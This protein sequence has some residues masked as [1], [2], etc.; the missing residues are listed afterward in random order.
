MWRQQALDDLARQPICGY[1]PSATPHSEPTALTALALQSHGLT[2]EAAKA[3]HWLAKCQ[4]KDGSLGVSST[5]Q[6]PSWPTSLAV[7]VWKA[8]GSAWSDRADRAIQW[9][10]SVQGDTIENTGNLVGHDTQIPGWPWVQGTHSWVEP[11]ALN[12][13]ALKASQHN[14]HRRCIV[15]VRMLIDRLLPA[16]GCNYGNT[17]VLGQALKPHVMPTGLTLL[18]LAK[19]PDGDMRIRAA[20]DYLLDAIS[21]HTTT[22]SLS[23]ALLGLAAQGVTLPHTQAVLASAVQRTNKNH[24]SPVQLALALLAAQEEDSLFVRMVRNET[25]I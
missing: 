6:Q 9:I 10:I 24:A 13:V 15:G 11:T 3:A 22:A 12:V 20:V 17:V 2:Q 7:L 8:L 25:I 5:E 19:E 14:D 16:G 23:Y 4:S 1:R 18:A 21:G